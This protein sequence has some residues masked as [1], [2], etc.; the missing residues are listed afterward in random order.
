M[1]VPGFGH[2]GFGV[3]VPIRAT[4][5]SGVV[6]YLADRDGGIT[7]FAEVAGEGGVF[8]FVGAGEEGSVTRRAISSGEKGVA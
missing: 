2:F 7:V 8:D 6:A 5:A 1:A 4:A 3:I